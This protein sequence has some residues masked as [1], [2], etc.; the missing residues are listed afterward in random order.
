MKRIIQIVV[1]ISYVIGCSAAAEAI[2]VRFPEN[3]PVSFKTSKGYV[4]VIKLILS[5]AG[6]EY[7]TVSWP[8]K[9]SLYSI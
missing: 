5:R 3:F 8:F 6:V 1:F 7:K 4:E 2:L 9:R